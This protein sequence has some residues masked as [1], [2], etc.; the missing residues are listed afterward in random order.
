MFLVLLNKR[1][2]AGKKK[3][4]FIIFAAGLIF[5]HYSTTY[6]TIGI[7]GIAWIIRILIQRLRISGIIKKFFSKSALLPL[8]IVKG[9]YN[10]ITLPIVILITLGSFLWSSILTDTSHGL[11]KTISESVHSIWSGITEDSKS[12]DVLYSLF[13]FQSVDLQK[14]LN[15]YYTSIKKE[16]LSQSHPSD[17]YDPSTYGNYQAKVVGDQTLPITVIGQTL[18]KFF[19]IEKFNFFLRQLQ[20]RLLQLFVLIGLI[21]LLFRRS[22]TKKI[23]T[24]YL[25]V[26]IGSGLVVLAVVVLPFL[27]VEYGLLRAFQQALVVLGI[28]VVIGSLVIIPGR[29]LYKIIFSLSLAIVMMLSSVGIIPWITGGY[30]SQLHLAN[31]GSYYDLYYTHKAEVLSAYWLSSLVSS[32]PKLETQSEVQ[33]DRFVAG[34]VGIIKE[35]NLLNDI[36]PSLIRKNS[37]VYLGYANAIEH[38]TTVSYSGNSI[39]YNYPVE[40]L[41]QNKNLI[42]ND[43]G[44]KIYK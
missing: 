13:S 8:K 23:S 27:S 41:D 30:Y 39:T 34:R 29:Y 9:Y 44:S 18:N 31:S 35:A 1:A 25:A 21:Y 4:L 14:Q 6:I 16:A 2:T 12:A 40:F 5:S 36:Y 42:Y 32:D 11:T 33:T 22:F 28:F 38:R 19:S 15:N 37:F 20:A 3:L 24:E 26:S 43:G 7:F 10:L 17:F